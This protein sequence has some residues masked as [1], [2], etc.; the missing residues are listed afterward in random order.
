MEDFKG[1]SSQKI[2]S[3]Y[4]MSVLQRIDFLNSLGFYKLPVEKRIQYLETIGVFDVDVNLDP[5]TIPLMPNDPE[6]DY[7]KEK[8][9]K[10]EDYNKANKWAEDFIRG[11]ISSGALTIEKIEGIENLAAL[12]NPSQGAIITLNHFNP[13]DSFS[14]DVAIHDAG[15]DKRLFKVIRERNFTNFP[16]GPIADYFKY[17]RTLPLSQNLNTMGLFLNSIRTLL[18]NGN[19][20]LVCSEQ[21]M[22]DNYQKP[23]PLKY[24]A[25]KWATKANVPVVPIF[26]GHTEKN[27]SASYTIFIGDLIY[28]QPNKPFNENTVSMRDKN[29][30][31]CRD[32]YEKYYG[33][34][35]TYDT[36]PSMFYNL[37]G[38]VRSTPGFEDMI[39]KDSIK[40]QEVTDK[41]EIE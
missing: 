34:K 32:M 1:I 2:K 30:I 20:V 25:Y 22:W 29:F 19:L 37:R 18:I 41:L 35:L 14:V 6:L 24:G 38:Y 36:D 5:P 7:L 28:P 40:S 4:G 13:L 9:E 3:F 12:K 17:G 11:I 10:Q 21:A 8:P 15:I 31:F 27:G 26:L 16:K 39:K 23:K 33:T